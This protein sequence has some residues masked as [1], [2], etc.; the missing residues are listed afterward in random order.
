MP[1]VQIGET[2]STII[3]RD[4]NGR[5][6]HVPKS[7]AAMA[8]VSTPASLAPLGNAVGPAP[9]PAPVEPA[10]PAMDMRP[11]P[12]P[13]GPPQMVPGP[14]GQRMLPSDLEPNKPLGPSAV[15][16]PPAPA[17]EKPHRTTK[18][19]AMD[20][21]R[22]IDEESETQ[23]RSVQES[24]E[25]KARDAEEVSQ[26]T[27]QQNAELAQKHQTE[28]DYAQRAAADAETKWQQ[29]SKDYQKWQD[30][31]V[32][33]NRWWESRT[34]GQS[35]MAWVGIA[36]SGLGM[37]MK[38]KGGENPA[39]QMIQSEINKDLQL[40]MEKLDR[41]GKALGNRGTLLNQFMQITGNKQ[42]ALGLATAAAKDYWSERIK[43]VGLRSADEQT[44][45]A[46]G[47]VSSQLRLEAGKDKEGVRVQLHQEAMQRSGEARG[48]ASLAL[49]R[50]KLALAKAEANK[51]PETKPED[52]NTVLF[53]PITGKPILDSQGQVQRIRGSDADVTAFRRNQAM[54]KESIGAVRELRDLQKRMGLMD[55]AKFAPGWFKSEEGKRARALWEDEV[56]KLIKARS[57]A[58]ATDNEV[59]RL[60]TIMPLESLTSGSTDAVLRDA[61]ERSISELQGSAN[62][63][64]LQWD[65]RHWATPLGP[66][67]EPSKASSDPTRPMGRVINTAGTPADQLGEDTL[68]QAIRDIETTRSEVGKRGVTNPESL[69]QGVQHALV[70]AENL[71]KAGRKTDAMQVRSS[72]ARLDLKVRQW[73]REQNYS[74]KNRGEPE[75]APLDLT[76]P[77]PQFQV[78]TFKE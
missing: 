59:A 65:V 73:E 34:T 32:N 76:R 11:G 29:L 48:W 20:R 8:G 23:Q 72:V 10:M 52:T 78:Q 2:A 5:E 25:L 74:R 70:I 40:Q 3:M 1:A 13:A 39:L 31:D 51:P 22:S 16:L 19:T 64:G 26:L 7:V 18:P 4:E 66:Q 67:G 62:T 55:K 77:P 14:F 56:S 17:P 44:R 57:G 28:A 75:M 30:T 71:E 9:A 61:E 24:A 54:S 43:E 33:Q 53:D 47:Q 36:L 38:G 58:Q 49:D 46:A 42:Q 37:A 35:I 45:I 69:R 21:V 60:K 6:Y 63:I 41:Q 50:E 27:E 15:M 68:N 12:K